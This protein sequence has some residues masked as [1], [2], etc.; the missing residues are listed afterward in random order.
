MATVSNGAIEAIPIENF[1]KIDQ[2]KLISQINAANPEIFS[3][4]EANLSALPNFNFFGI[5]LAETPAFNL[6][7]TIN[8]WLILIPVLA[9]VSSWLSMV[10]MRKWNPNPATAGADQQTQASMKIM[11]LMMPLMSLFI[12]F[13]FSGMLGIYWVYQSVISILQSFIL[14]RVMPMPTYSE[15]ELKAMKKAQKAAEKAQKEALRAQPKYRSLHYIDEDD[16][17]ELP[18]LKN[19]KPTNTKKNA[20]IDVPTIKD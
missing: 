2:I 5:N 18:E 20:G 15:E 9:A 11:D 6:I 12:A 17:D 10:L 1:G 8:G 14:S 19:A 4:I 7:G 13:N 3:D 16:Y